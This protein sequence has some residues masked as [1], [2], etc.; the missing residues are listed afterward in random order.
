MHINADLIR[1]LFSP[2]RPLR[3][4]LGHI[5]RRLAPLP[6]LHRLLPQFR[7]V[8]DEVINSRDTPKDTLILTEPSIRLKRRRNLVHL[9]HPTVRF[10]WHARQPFLSFRLCARTVLIQMRPQL[11]QNSDFLSRG[12]RLDRQCSKAFGK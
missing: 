7:P 6:I 11:V 8:R 4:Q 3:H 1:L 10:R 2:L 5:I 12:E 9:C